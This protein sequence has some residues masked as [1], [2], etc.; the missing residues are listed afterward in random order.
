M[1]LLSGSASRR[2][3]PVLAWV[4]AAAASGCVDPAAPDPIYED[5]L[6]VYSVLRTGSST[7]GVVIEAWPAGGGYGPVTGATVSISGPG[8]T[9]TLVEAEPGA[10]CQASP[11]GD[12]L[13]SGPGCYTATLPQPVAPLETYTLDIGLPGGEVITG[14]T[15]TPAPPDFRATTDTLEAL[16]ANTPEGLPVAIGPTQVFDA[17]GAARVEVAFSIAAGADPAECAVEAHVDPYLSPALIE[18]HDFL[19]WRL[20]CEGSTSGW[21]VLDLRLH[22]AAY[23]ESYASYYRSALDDRGFSGTQDAFGLT[24]AVGVFGS[25]ATTTAAVVLKCVGPQLDGCQPPPAVP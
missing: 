19:F 15:T 23:D 20:I 21:S 7:V 13:P 22:A 25:A 12:P 14:R 8:Q 24:G 11:E 5:Q 2:A 16:Y 10:S 9:T 1:G 4:T 17:P 18:S 6:V 3:R